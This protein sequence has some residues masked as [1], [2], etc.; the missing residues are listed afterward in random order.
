[1]TPLSSYISLRLFRFRHLC[2]RRRRVL[3]VVVVISRGVPPTYQSHVGSTFSLFVLL[4]LLLLVDFFLCFKES[5]C[6]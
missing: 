4:L 3:L 1:M 5:L 6:P 2:R